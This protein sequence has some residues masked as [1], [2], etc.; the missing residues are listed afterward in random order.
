MRYLALA[1]DYDGTLAKDG[2]VDAA[3]LEALDR[4]RRSGRRLILVTG[5]ELPEL[6]TVFPRVK[7]FDRVVAENGALLFDPATR[8]IRILA[9][10]PP[11]A[12][13]DELKRRGI[14]PISV[15]R[16]IVATHERHQRSVAQAIASLKLGLR[17]ILNKDWAM[18]L[19]AGVDKATGLAAALRE[20]GISPWETIGVGDA[21]ND[22]VFL[23]FCGGSAAV[24]NALPAIRASAQLVTNGAWGSGVTELIERVLAND[25]PPAAQDR[26][27]S[28]FDSGKRLGYTRES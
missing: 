1:T 9:D 12:F 18:V 24:A 14:E 10:P 25:L 28:P 2:R 13:V 20:M 27:G 3:A 15:G 22:Q 26:S 23:E 8:A 5:R 6:L 19:P 7:A 16:V 4:L 11:A 17:V 21:E